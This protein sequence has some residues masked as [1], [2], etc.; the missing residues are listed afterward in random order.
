VPATVPAICRVQYAG[1]HTSADASSDA[2]TLDPWQ[3][4]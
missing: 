4:I 1:V 3:Q 2:E